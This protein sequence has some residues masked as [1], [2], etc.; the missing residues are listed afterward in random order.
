MVFSNINLNLYKSF[1]AVY[2]AKN[3]SRAAKEMH[4]SQPTV[5]YNIKELEKQLGVQL[6][7]TH[8]RGV[9]QTN[10]ADELYKEIGPAFAKIAVGENN[11][12]EFN[13]TS[14]GVI[15]IAC[16]TNF[17]GHILSEHILKFSLQYPNMQFEV[18]YRKIE[19]ALDM[20]ERR[21]VDLVFSTLPLDKKTEYDMISL[22]ELS[23]TYFASCDFAKTHNLT[24]VITKETFEKLP[25][26][27]LATQEYERRPLAYVE[28]QEMLYRLVMK[29][30][31]VG[32]CIQQF[33][34]LN[35]PN[36]S[37]FRFKVEGKELPNKTLNCI[38]DEALLSKS[39][40][41]FLTELK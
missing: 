39:V 15:R 23:E 11:V 28:T 40:K 32:H 17:A 9:E 14:I 27:S 21:S 12:K 34:T 36:D 7:V 24:P 5:S 10:E 4:I 33:L 22:A 26:I 2:K 3:I 8:A 30:L 29:G 31:G 37:V 16:V 13:E 6:F 19:E 38:Y 20:L 41:T 25:L 1:I 18:V 35:H